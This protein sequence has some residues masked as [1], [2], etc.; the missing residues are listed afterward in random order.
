MANAREDPGGCEG[1]GGTERRRFR[2]ACGVKLSVRCEGRVIYCD[3]CNLARPSVPKSEAELIAAALAGGQIRQ[4]QR[5]D[6][7]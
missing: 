7:C 4:K 2:G 3:I 1:P 5:R 6:D